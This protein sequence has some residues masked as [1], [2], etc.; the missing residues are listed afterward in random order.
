[1]D[2]F[3]NEISDDYFEQISYI[4]SYGLAL[5]DYGNEFRDENGMIVIIPEDKWHLFEVIA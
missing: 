4:N 2:D 3:F 1:M 5:D